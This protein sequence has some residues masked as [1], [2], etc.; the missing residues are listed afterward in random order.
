M[1]GA[2][3]CDKAGALW[4]RRVAP[5]AEPAAQSLKAARELETG[6]DGEERKDQ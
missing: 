6:G 5:F 1:G 2:E 3:G 4:R